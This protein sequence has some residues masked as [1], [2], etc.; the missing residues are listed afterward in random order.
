MYSV[1]DIARLHNDKYSDCAETFALPRKRCCSTCGMTSPGLAAMTTGDEQLLKRC[2]D[3]PAR[4][5]RARHCSKECQRLDWVSR[6]RGECAEAAGAAG[7]K[8]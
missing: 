1:L 4:G 3:C 8:V 2:G 7:S 5:L 6:H